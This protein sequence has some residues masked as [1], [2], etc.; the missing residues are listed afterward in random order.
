MSCGDIKLIEVSETA[1]WGRQLPS[2]MR[3][4]RLSEQ[5]QLAPGQ[6][7]VHAGDGH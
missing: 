6:A 4:L 5:K 7:V 2:Q 3:D 1:L